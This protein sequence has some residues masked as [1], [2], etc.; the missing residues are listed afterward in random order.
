[1]FTHN[2]SNMKKLFLSAAV[3]IFIAPVY[4]QSVGVGLTAPEQ[5]LHVRSATASEGILLEAVNPILQLRQSNTPLPGF[6]NTGFIQLNGD[7]IRL[8]T[9]SAN[10][11]G[12]LVIR[13]NGTD[14]MFVDSA[15]NVTLGTTYKAAAGYR[16]SVNGKIMAEGVRVQFDNAWPDYVFDKN[17]KLRSLT[18]LDQFIQKEKHL[19]NIPSAAAV[20]AAG[21]DLGD[22]NSK[23]L[24]KIEELTLYII[25]MDKK[26]KELEQRLL[27]VEQKNNNN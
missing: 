3:V 9:N 23:L 4:S 2:S 14:R 17:Y 12:K 16:L 8:G 11:S 27:I 18:E 19:P 26:N 20:A 6:S 1:M 10:N 5:Q 22:M 13:T 24:E 21:V 25:E 15:G 7:D